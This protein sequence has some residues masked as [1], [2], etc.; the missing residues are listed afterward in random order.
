MKRQFLIA[1]AIAAIAVA[2]LVTMISPSAQSHG[3]PTTCTVRTSQ[4]AAP[5]TKA[6]PFAG[7]DTPSTPTVAVAPAASC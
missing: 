5:A 1:L 4:S 2:G 7:G 3:D 6:A